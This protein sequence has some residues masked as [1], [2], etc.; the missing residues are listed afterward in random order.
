MATFI[1]Y[2]CRQF[3]LDSIFWNFFA[4][5]HGKGPC[6]SLGGSVKRMERQAVLSRKAKV[7]SATEMAMAISPDN[8][9]VLVLNDVDRVFEHLQ[10]SNVMEHDSKKVMSTI[11]SY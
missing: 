8:I 7:Q 10:Y 6:D 5:S 1:Q 9:E 3:S 2:I 4:T 11:N